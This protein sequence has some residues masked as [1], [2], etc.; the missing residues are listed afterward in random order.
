MAHR[1]DD[2]LIIR[3][4]KIKHLMKIGLIMLHLVVHMIG[5]KAILGMD[6]IFHLLLRIIMERGGAILHLLH[7]QP[8]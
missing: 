8:R 6:L 1:V 7:P 4:P 5:G 3:V 2:K